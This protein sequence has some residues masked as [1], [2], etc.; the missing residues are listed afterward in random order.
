VSRVVGF[1]YLYV[2]Y[3]TALLSLLSLVL[4]FA[5]VAALKCTA[6]ERH[7]RVALGRLAAAESQGSCPV[8]LSRA[9]LVIGS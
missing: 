1:V 2:S 3:A 6:A 5:G 7:C 8:P 4:L 9:R